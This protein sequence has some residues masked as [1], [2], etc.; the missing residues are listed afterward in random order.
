MK[1]W[2]FNRLTCLAEFDVDLNK[3]TVSMTRINYDPLWSPFQQ[4]SPSFSDFE[5]FLETR[6]FP[7]QR[8]N[9]KE[10]LRLFDLDHYDPWRIVV[11]THGT[12]ANDPCW[13][14]FETD[15]GD[16]E[17][18]LLGGVLNVNATKIRSEACRTLDM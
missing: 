12:V 11:K 3:Q 16:I 18:P 4:Q 2:F 10:L 7:R 17:V 8:Y 1:L 13:L 5:W 9:L 14:L 15:I 6:C